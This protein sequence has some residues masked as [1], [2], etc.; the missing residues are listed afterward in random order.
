LRGVLA[1]GESAAMGLGGKL[2]AKTGLIVEGGGF[3][4]LRCS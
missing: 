1:D 2:I 3:G 4:H